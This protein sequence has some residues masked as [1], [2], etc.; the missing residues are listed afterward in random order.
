[1]FRYLIHQRFFF[2]NTHHSSRFN[3]SAA[4]TLYSYY[5]SREGSA[6]AFFSYH[7]PSIVLFKVGFFYQCI[8]ELFGGGGVR[9]GRVGENREM[10]E[11]GDKSFLVRM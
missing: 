8:H 11:W 9:R 1:M 2:S 5:F 3:R 10:E 7:T 6:F 4:G